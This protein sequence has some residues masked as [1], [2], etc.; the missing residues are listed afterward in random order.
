MAKPSGEKKI[1]VVEDTLAM[2]RVFELKL[3]S[4]GFQP[5]V[6]A[7]GEHALA[8]LGKQQFDLILLD[9]M[10]PGISGFD[11]LSELRRRG[12]HTPVVVFSNLGQPEDQKRAQQLGARE[13]F[14]KTNVSLSDMVARVKEILA[15]PV[16]HGV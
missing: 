10:L 6:V 11:V 8:Q 13:Y 7:D 15:Q 1:L 2:G 3:K 14:I 5:T 16:T 4:A 12:D 9:L